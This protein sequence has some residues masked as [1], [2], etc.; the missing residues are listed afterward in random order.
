MT[1]PLQPAASWGA[2]RCFSPSCWWEKIQ[3]LAYGLESFRMIACRRARRQ[4]PPKW[5]SGMICLLQCLWQYALI[6]VGVQM[7]RNAQRIL[8]VG[9]SLRM[10]ELNCEGHDLALVSAECWRLRF[11]DKPGASFNSSREAGRFLWENTQPEYGLPGCKD[12]SQKT[13]VS[14]RKSPTQPTL[15]CFLTI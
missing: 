12:P 4:R 1:L 11:W 3:D 6:S 10:S 7:N 14:S 2:H 8:T 9:F 13:E 15:I 5:L